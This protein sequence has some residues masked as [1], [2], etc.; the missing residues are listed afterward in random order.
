VTDADLPFSSNAQIGVVGPGGATVVATD[1]LLRRHRVDGIIRIQDDDFALLGGTSG[2][3][4]H[5]NLGSTLNRAA[6]R[7]VLLP[8][9][10]QGQRLPDGTEVLPIVDPDRFRVGTCLSVQQRVPIGNVTAADFE[11]S[12]PTIRTAAQLQAVLLARYRPMFPEMTDEAILSHGCAVTRL[13]L[14]PETP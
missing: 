5:F 12:L 13:L 4:V 6:E 10:T 3:F 7:Y 9:V 14:A 2:L 1:T 8:I 11:S